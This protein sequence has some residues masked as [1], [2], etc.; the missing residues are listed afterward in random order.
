MR[1]VLDTNV[2]V[3][4]LVTPGG[5]P[6]RVYA[7]CLEPDIVLLTS[8]PLIAELRGVMSQKFAWPSEEI[9]EAIAELLLASE[10]VEPAEAVR[11][12]PDDPDDDRV[13]EAALAGEAELIVSGDRH[14]LRLDEWQR[15]P[16]LRPREA[17][18]V[19][20]EAEE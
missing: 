4:A 5:S 15:I 10:V 9:D 2:L 11:D 1:L 12:V 7:R 18:D 8:A 16:I 13:L 6:F 14:L 3:S 20:G 17:L 19:I